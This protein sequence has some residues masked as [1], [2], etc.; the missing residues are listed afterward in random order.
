MDNSI[1]K[2]VASVMSDVP[3]LAKGEKNSHGNYNFASIDDFLEAVRPLMAKAGLVIV[4][5]EEDF[6]VIGEGKDTWLK[7]RY[8][9]TLHA[10][11]A[12]YGPIYRT[13]M[14]RASMGSQAFGAAQS[15]A[16]K[17]FLRS[18]FKIA[19][20][21]G[22]AIDADSHAQSNLPANARGHVPGFDD[23]PVRQGRP[24]ALTGPLKTRKA[25]F[26]RYG[27]IVRELNSCGDEET[28]D[29]FLISIAPELD[30]F[31]DELPTAWKGDGAD[32]IGMEAEIA[33]IRR[34]ITEGE[35]GEPA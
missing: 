24:P 16:E 31:R 6:E 17:Q 33:K 29:V 30:Q 14:V 18:L 5:D 12:L 8:A 7:M 19:T 34:E 26:A 15:Y 10:A 35:G 32:F 1:V 11:D 27:E 25:A 3:K 22:G 28:L 21:E 4:S 2:A 23:Q 13:T 20:G 9:F